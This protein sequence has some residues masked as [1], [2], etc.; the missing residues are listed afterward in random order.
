[1]DRKIHDLEVQLDAL[2]V[3][4][5]VEPAEDHANVYS[6]PKELEGVEYWLFQCCIDGDMYEDADFVKVDN[7]DAVLSTLVNMVNSFS[8]TISRNRK[9]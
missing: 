8:R 1:M 7:R 3:T 2:G 5:T 6:F 4:K 9:K